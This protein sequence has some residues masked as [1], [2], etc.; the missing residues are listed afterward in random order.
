MGWSLGSQAEEGLVEH[1]LTSCYGVT[2]ARSLN[3]RPLEGEPTDG[4]RLRNFL[5]Q[6]RQE[7]VGRRWVGGEQAR[8]GKADAKDTTDPAA[9]VGHR[10]SVL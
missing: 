4:L 1:S 8:K 9:A 2:A 5:R 10:N 3:P 6:W 7:L